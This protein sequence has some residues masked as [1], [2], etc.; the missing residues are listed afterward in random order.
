MIEACLYAGIAAM[1]HHFTLQFTLV[2]VAIDGGLAII[3]T[4]LARS[5]T[6]NS[7]A[8]QGLLREGNG[9]MNL[10]AMFATAGG[11]VIAGAVV[12]WRGASTALLVDAVSFLG[13][14]FVIV[15]APG[16]HIESD[17][18]A[19][20]SGRIKAG[21]SLLRTHPALRRLLLAITLTVGVSSVAVPV[22]VVFAK[23]TLHSGSEGYGFLLTAW[24]VGM[25][26]GGA[27][28]AAA[29]TVALMRILAVS[30][31]LGAVGYIGLALSPTLA[32]A[33]GFSCLGGIGN[34]AAWVAAMTAVQERIPL[35]TQSAVMSVFYALNQLMPAV[36]FVV[37][38]VVTA[39][40]SPRVAY[41]ISGLGTAIALV[42]FAIRGVDR[43]QLDSLPE[44]RMATGT[45]SGPQ[46][47]AGDRVEE[48][49][50][51]SD[52]TYPSSPLFSA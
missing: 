16:I 35:R 47:P 20:T 3:A 26:F 15:T 33:C 30:T 19:G 28:F 36:G 14:A 41:A 2:L 39:L 11:P 17:R 42:I 22:E 44:P 46:P 9:F 34:G 52:R 45:P 27:G 13:A 24:G 7:L 12:A 1:T 18:E 25:I 37:G 23:T 6:T 8:G 4:T 32:V 5:A 31:A 51:S 49:N 29:R 48:E 38:G 21:L 43:V 10:G 40:S 50:T